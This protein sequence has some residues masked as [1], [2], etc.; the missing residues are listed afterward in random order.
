MILEVN[1]VGFPSQLN[2]IGRVN[3]LADENRLEKGVALRSAHLHC[4]HSGATGIMEAQLGLL[5]A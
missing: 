5:F 3:N 1:S 2:P 4:L